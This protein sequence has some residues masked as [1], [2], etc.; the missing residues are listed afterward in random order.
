MFITV[1][2]SVCLSIYLFIYPSTSLPIYGS[3]ALVDFAR[4][5][6]FLIYAHSVRLLERKNTPPQGRYLNTEQ[7]KQRINASSWIRIQD[8]G[9]SAGEDRSCLILRGHSDR[10]VDNST[11]MLMIG[12]IYYDNNY[13]CCSSSGL[14]AILTV[15]K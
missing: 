7:H 3:T 4:F 14:V 2:L 9:V 6:S 1:Y 11:E 15:P 5:F 10:V 12:Q 8:P 13:Y